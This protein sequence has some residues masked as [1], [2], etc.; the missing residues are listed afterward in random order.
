MIHILGGSGFV[1]TR[2]KL[3]L[4]KFTS[5]DLI[6]DREEF[7]DIR[8]KSSLCEK[9]TKEGKVVLLAAVHRDDISPIAKYYE[10]NEI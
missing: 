1:G 3:V 10:T 7:C 8:V 2:L 9:L 5:F 4:E 6:A